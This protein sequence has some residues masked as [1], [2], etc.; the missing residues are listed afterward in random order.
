MRF[1]SRLR[2]TEYL[3][4]A[5]HEPAQLDVTLDHL[6]AVNR[7]LGGTRVVLKHL[8]QWLPEGGGGGRGRGGGG[9]SRVLDV[10]TGAGD[11]PRAIVAWAAKG[12]RVVDVHGV[13]IQLSI[14][15]RARDRCASESSIRVAV[16]DGMRLPFADNTFDVATSSMTLHHLDD[17]DTHAFVAELSRVSTRAVIINDLERHPINY[18]GARVLAAT[19]WR[20]DRYTR[21]DGPISVLRSFSPRELRRV[22]EKAG[23]RNVVVHRHFPYRLALVG[24]PV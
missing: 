17:S 11:I 5:E 2:A 3:D 8:R 10:G 6:V 7:W 21:H 12:R 9:C 18:Y 20:A 15:F 14:A 13:D 19:V 24:Q 22:G 23:L 4:A 1:S 16:A